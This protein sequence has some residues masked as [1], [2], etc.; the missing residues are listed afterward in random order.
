MQQENPEWQELLRVLKK[1]QV[2]QRVW[3]KRMRV[4]EEKIQWEKVEKQR[5]KQRERNERRTNSR[6]WCRCLQD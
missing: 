4:L 5:E 3:D 1:K 6:E 2:E